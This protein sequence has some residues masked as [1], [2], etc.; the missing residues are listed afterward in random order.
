MIKM[1]ALDLDNTL[2]NSRK[3][4]SKANEKILKSL[5]N[6]GQ[7]I[8]LCSGRPI[9]AIMPMINQLG[10]N[11]PEDFSITFNGG[12][13]QNNASKKILF[14][15]TLNK[16]EVKT[17]YNFAKNLGFPLDVVGQSQ[18]YSLVD[19]GKSSYQKFMRGLL[20][21]T[22]LNFPDL[23]E[24]QPYGKVVSS[25]PGPIIDKIANN[26]PPVISKKFHVIP[27]RTTLMEFMAH[28]VNKA[29]GLEKLLAHFG[30]SFDNLM[31]FGDHKNDIAMLKSARI[32][33]A[34][35]N[36]IPPVKK[37]ANALADTNDHDGV[38]KYLKNY[39]HL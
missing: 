5:H 21:F 14:Q 12:L 34:M 10:L 4:I 28:N 35:G 20:K 38:G 16:A 29:S 11:K 24:K 31:A 15:K 32:G 8:V 7:Q 22:D 33:V 9:Q 2:L 18:V 30:Q 37:I 13:V 39:F 19:L 25:A 26:L 23:P 1:I 17:I 27:S 36:A 6:A 3:E